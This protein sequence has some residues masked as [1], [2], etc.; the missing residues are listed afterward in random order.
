VLH[1]QADIENIAVH[2]SYQ[3]HLSIFG[4]R[5]LLLHARMEVRQ[6]TWLVH[7]LPL[8]VVKSVKQFL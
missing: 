8:Y 5:R 4:R 7:E 6:K 3:S 1:E 2:F